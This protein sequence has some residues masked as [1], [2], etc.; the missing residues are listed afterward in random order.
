MAGTMVTE[1]M[2]ETTATETMGEAT[3][4]AI[5]TAGTITTTIRFL[6]RIRTA[7]IH[8]LHISIHN[9]S[10]MG[11]PYLLLVCLKWAM[12]RGHRHHLGSTALAEAMEVSKGISRMVMGVGMG[13]VA[14]AMGV[15]EVVDINHLIMD[16]AEPSGENDM[17]LAC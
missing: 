13:K 5:I 4:M 1:T 15:D 11:L 14:E 7:P 3:D 16:V 9:F 2:V 17:L 12:D 8:S 10:Q 6:H